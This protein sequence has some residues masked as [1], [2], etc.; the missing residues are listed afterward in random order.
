M[1]KIAYHPIY[2]HPLPL[3]HRFPMGKY[4]LLYHQLLH[5]GTCT[6][7]NFFEPEIPN[8]K[9][10]FLA[11][12]PEYVSDLMN[13]TLDPKIARRIGFPLDELLI[14]REIVIADGTLKACEYALKNGISMNI[15]GGTHHAFTNKGEGFCLFNDQAIGARYLQHKN[16]AD[17]ILIIDLDVHQGN[18]T[19]EIFKDDDSVFTF[20]MHGKSN[21]PFIK[22][23]SNLDI[24]LDNGVGDEE[25]LQILKE[26]IPKLI[27]E[28]EPDFIFYLS[29][30][31]VIESDKLGKLSLS[32]EGCKERDRIVLQSC[33]DFSIPVVCSMGGGYSKDIKVIVEAHANTFRTAQDIFF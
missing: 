7:E 16:L 30:V 19:A 3:G 32:M 33:K 15:A 2:R 27:L 31:D 14:E 4:E 20:S 5:E 23:Q 10:I 6:E 12:D 26:T 29:G 24:A 28:Q 9:Y 22:E 13:L 11:H 18:G 25:Y 8:N 1:L 17:K 21:Y